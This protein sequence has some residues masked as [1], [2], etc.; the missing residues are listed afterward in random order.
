MLDLSKLTLTTF[1]DIGKNNK[2]NFL[3]SK[4]DRDSTTW[5]KV[6]SRQGI[7]NSSE[8][9]LLERTW[10]VGKMGQKLERKNDVGN[11]LLKSESFQLNW[12]RSWKAAIEVGNIDQKNGNFIEIFNEKFNRKTHLILNFASSAK[13]FKFINENFPISHFS[14]FRSFPLHITSLFSFLSWPVSMAPS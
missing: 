5:F 11:W 6:L 2:T 7:K 8:Y 12:K 9:V 3:S 4:S 1:R 10:R 13:F 14:T